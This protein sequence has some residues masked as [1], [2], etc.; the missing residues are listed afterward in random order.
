VIINKHVRPR[1]TYRA[2]PELHRMGLD[3]HG[4]LSVL[5]TSKQ[6]RFERKLT[7]KLFYAR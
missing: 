4:A 6:R 7:I 1:N 2:V 5:E 3:L